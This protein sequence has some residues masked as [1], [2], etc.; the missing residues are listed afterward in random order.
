MKRY[1]AAAA[2]LA[3][4]GSLA[5]TR[6]T[7]RINPMIDLLERKQPVFGVY[8]PRSGRGAEAQKEPA[9][10][11][12]E[13]LA[14]ERTDFIFDGS[15]EGN[16]ERGY[17]GFA[18]FARGMADAGFLRR[19][20]DPRLSHP[21][22]VK[23]H[24]IAPDPELAA[25]NIARQLDLGVSTIVFVGVESAEEL[26]TG[27][28]AMRYA[29]HGGTRPDRVGSAHAYW[30]MSEQ[31]YRAKADVWPL[32]PEGELVAWAIVES[33]EGLA[34]LREIAAVPGVAVLFPGAGTL[35]GVFT[36]TDASGE[37]VL[38]TDGWEGAIQ[39][40]LA[41][42][43]EFDRACGYPATASDI[44]MRMAQGFSVFIMGWGEAGFEA[45]EIGR[46]AAGRT[47]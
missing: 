41:A 23:M 5:M 15:M 9:E 27:V 45:V 44:E 24:E 7:A 42:C 22:V 16:F 21:L 38:D 8:A 36:S 20:P 46:A 1:F 11:A 31:E 26:R 25:A 12:R 29:A 3:T 40:V 34:N 14:Y 37:R 10:L 4:L 47:D 13:A 35:R 32:N 43:Q 39:Q 2:V 18:A 33:R 30:G 17:A 28:A 6:D 19:D